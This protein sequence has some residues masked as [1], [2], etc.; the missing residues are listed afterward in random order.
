MH[1]N[2]FKN[3]R[4]ITLIALVVTIVVLIILAGV[5]ISLSLGENG[6]I[7]KSKDSK[8]NMEIASLKEKVQMDIMENQIEKSLISEQELKKV[9]EKY[10]DN[11]PNINEIKKDTI[12]KAKEEYGNYEIKIS[13]IYNGIL[14]KKGITAADI[15]NSANKSEFYGSIVKGYTCDN[16]AGVSNWKI[17]Y[18]DDRNIYL[19]TEDYINYNYC[20]DSK[21]QKIYKND[22][23]KLSMNNIV[24]DYKGSEDITDT[25]IRNLNKSYFEYLTE[26]STTTTSNNIKAVAYMT[27][28]DVW[29]V[30]SGDKAEYAI[31]GPTI[32]ML[33]NSYN[34]KYNTNYKAKT[35]NVNGY[36]ISTDGG[37][38]WNDYITD[39]SQYLNA[40][41]SLYVISKGDKALATWIASP[42]SGDSIPRINTAGYVG[43]GSYGGYTNN[44]SGFRPVV[45]LNADIELEKDNDGNY[46]ILE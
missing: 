35:T 19:I 18:A 38:T 44:S 6:I 43:K 27:D 7:N 11:V 17:L 34:Q 5:A 40:E 24:K 12:L 1:K 33:F 15:S 41:D 14:T 22:I 39:A 21:T 23:Y 8:E 16:S 4:A 46:K 45:C 20:P 29:K 10:F 32:E 2:K 25:R 36:Q 42:S 28:I 31:G 3:E 9:L 30:F 13:E 26:K 37:T